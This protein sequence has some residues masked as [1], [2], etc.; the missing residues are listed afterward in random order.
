MWKVSNQAIS[1]QIDNEGNKKKYVHTNKLVTLLRD[2]EYKEYRMMVFASM[3]AMRLFL[4]ARALI[5]FPMRSANTLEITNGERRAL[6]K[7][8]ARRNLPLLKRFAAKKS[9]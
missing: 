3:R 7:F 8:S 5:N 4:R 6:R 9:G 1:K 2:N